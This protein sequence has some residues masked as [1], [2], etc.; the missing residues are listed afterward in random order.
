MPIPNPTTPKDSSVSG[1]HGGPSHPTPDLKPYS[2]SGGKKNEIMFIKSRSGNLIAFDDH[3]HTLR[4]QDKTGNA[5]IRLTE[6]RIEIKQK[7]GD[8]N[9][10]S[11]KETRFDCTTYE[12]HATNNISFAAGTD[13]SLIGATMKSKS[14]KN[15]SFSAKKSATFLSFASVS[16]TAM[17]SITCSGKKQV[18]VGTKSGSQTYTA[19]KKITISSKKDLSIQGKSMVSMSGIAGCDFKSSNTI[20]LT[21]GGILMGASMCI[22][23]N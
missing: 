22:N 8:I 6:D 10:T 2:L 9:V 18:S 1:H 20:T 12:V 7:T 19:I 5:E 15:T 23:I 3:G 21:A 14:G 13:V 4:F 11:E 16:V 17:G